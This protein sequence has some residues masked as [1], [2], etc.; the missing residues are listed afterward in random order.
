MYPDRDVGIR[1]KRNTTP[2]RAINP[3]AV[4][5]FFDLI[6]RGRD[7]QRMGPHTRKAYDDL[8]DIL[9]V[10]LGAGG[11]RLS[12]AA[13]LHVED[14]MLDGETPRLRSNKAVVYLP[15]SGD[16]H[17]P[18]GMK[19]RK[20]ENAGAYIV[21]Q[22][23]KTKQN[24]VL[25]VDKHAEEVLRRRAAEV[26]TGLLFRTSNGQPINLNNLRRALRDTIRGTDFDGWVSTHTMRRSIGTIVAA[27]YGA[28][29]AAAVLGHAN[30]ATIRVS[31]IEHVDVAPDVSCDTGQLR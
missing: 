24:R 16:W 29:V 7:R 31:Y 30:V 5:R 26:G 14:L 1:L 25:S 12:E 17:I 8:L 19:K 22:V 10:Q 20:Y 27:K 21:Q 28:E 2:T 23:T 6:V 15:P 4:P 18:M 11:M 3:D 13:G 9:T